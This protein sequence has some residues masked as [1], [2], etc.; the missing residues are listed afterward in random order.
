MSNYALVIFQLAI[1]GVALREQSLNALQNGWTIWWYYLRY[2]ANNDEYD[3]NNDVE[4]NES[5][6]EAVQTTSS[7]PDNGKLLFL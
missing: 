3:E 5:E 4:D 1:T 2:K 6:S 7:T